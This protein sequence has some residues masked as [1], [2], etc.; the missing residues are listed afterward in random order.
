MQ[1]INFRFWL[2]RNAATKL[3]FLNIFEANQSGTH[4]DPTN[5]AIAD[6]DGIKTQ[7]REE[8]ETLYYFW[9]DLILMDFFLFILDSRQFRSDLLIQKHTSQNAYCIIFA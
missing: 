2:L 6:T 9:R 7:I 5:Q 8:N 4:D 3:K 1:T